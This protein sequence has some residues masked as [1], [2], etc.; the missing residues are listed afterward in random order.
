[1]VHGIELSGEIQEGEGCY[2]PFSHMKEEIGLNIKEG[3]IS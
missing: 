1:M 3:T 2:R